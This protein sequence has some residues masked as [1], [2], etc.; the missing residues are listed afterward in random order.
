MDQEKIGVFIS[1]LRKEQG[2]TQQQLADA[3]GVSNK[4]IS[5]WECGKGMPELALIVPLCHIL[6]ISINEFLSGEHLLENGYTEKAEVNMMNLLQETEN[7]KKKSRSS[8]L[9]F[10]ITVI[11][12]LFVVLYSVITNMGIGMN[13]LFV[14]MPTFLSMFLATTLFL[15]GTNLGL[16]FFDSFRIIFGK[17]KSVSIKQLF[18]AKSAIKL[19]KIT[20]LG[21]GFLES[22]ISF[23]AIQ[24]MGEG[25][26]LFTGLSISISIALNGIL[27]GLIGF[28]LLLPIQVRLEIM[29]M[30]KQEDSEKKTELKAQQYAGIIVTDDNL[31]QA[32]QD[33]AN[34]ASA[35]VAI[36]EFRKAKKKEM[37]VNIDLMEKQCKELISIIEG[38]EKPLQAGI[39]VYDN[40]KREKRRQQAL[41]FIQTTA[42]SLGLRAKWS[43]LCPGWNVKQV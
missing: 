26:L 35:R 43:E 13:M 23:M 20:F 1:T 33:R 8:L 38:V 34:L 18:Q 31:K 28:L 39:D 22:C 17:K 24:P 3:I 16:P 6:Q 2:M 27:Y 30:Q 9:A 37:S 42:D 19:A 7:S 25:T 15:L 21:M 5:K 12:F 4:T 36:D 40:E 14:D 41:K 10:G 29:Y 32:K 11:I